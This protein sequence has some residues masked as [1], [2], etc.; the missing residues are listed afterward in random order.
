M[1]TTKPEWAPRIW[2]DS[3]NIY[4]EFPSGMVS[5]FP[6]AEAGLSKALK[7]IP[8]AAVVPGMLTGAQNIYDKLVRPKA[9]KVKRKGKKS[10][11][12]EI[13]E[14][15]KETINEILKQVMGE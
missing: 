12:L 2:T 11:K 13:S 5:R 4:L 6:Y 1:N 7:S 10:V 15:Q 14:Q 3:Y 9:I 8:N